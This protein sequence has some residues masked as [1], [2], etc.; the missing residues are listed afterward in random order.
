MTSG[1]RIAFGIV[2]NDSRTV[3]IMSSGGRRI[4]V[5]VVANVYYTAGLHG[6]QRITFQ[7]H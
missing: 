7:H 2:P 5:P 1:G 6:V 4:T 3:T